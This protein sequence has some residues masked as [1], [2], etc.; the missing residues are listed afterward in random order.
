MTDAFRF[1]SPAKRGVGEG[2]V[3]CDENETVI[4][5]RAKLRTRIKEPTGTNDLITI[6]N[7]KVDPIRYNGTERVHRNSLSKKH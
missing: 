4:S 6:K 2:G 7:R 3:H 5:F 1:L